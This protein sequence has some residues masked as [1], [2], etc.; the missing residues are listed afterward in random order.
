LLKEVIPK[1]ARVAAL[2]NPSNPNTAPLLRETEA[3]ARDLRVQLQVV[4]VRDPAQLDSAFSAMT[5]ERAGAVV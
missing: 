4:E 1:V 5:R 2:S 3:A